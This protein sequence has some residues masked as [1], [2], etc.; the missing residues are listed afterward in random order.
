[1]GQRCQFLQELDITYNEVDDEGF[2]SIP[3]YAFSKV[4]VS[5]NDL[6]NFF[7]V[8]R[9]SQDALSFPV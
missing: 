3:Q 4:Y 7:Q 9:L 5:A 6:C 2:L 1:M 8:R